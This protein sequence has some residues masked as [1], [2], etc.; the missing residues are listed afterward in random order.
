MLI[1]IV[2]VCCRSTAKVLDIKTK[3]CLKVADC[4]QTSQVNFPTSS[5]NATVY[6]L[7]KMCCSTDLCNA[8]PGLPGT[9]GLSLALAAVTALFVANV[10]VWQ[11][12]RWMTDDTK[13]IHAYP[14]VYCT[15]FDFT[16]VYELK[17]NSLFC[18]CIF[19]DLSV[20]SPSPHFTVTDIKSEDLKCKTSDT[21]IRDDLRSPPHI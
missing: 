6:T 4:N 17:F 18:F 5:S 13:C 20:T 9:S 21:D 3:G 1:V 11:K 2:C 19:L 15:F 8:A 7:T 12:T 14:E 10:L 16:R